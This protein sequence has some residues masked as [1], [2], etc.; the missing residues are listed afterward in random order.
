MLPSSSAQRHDNIQH[1]FQR[2]LMPLSFFVYCCRRY[3][4][5]PLAMLLTSCSRHFRHA[6]IDFAMSNI[7]M[8]LMRATTNIIMNHTVVFDA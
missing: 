5:A 2:L 8:P 1:V 7:K 6:L 4:Y 3:G